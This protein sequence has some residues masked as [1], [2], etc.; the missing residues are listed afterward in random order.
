LRVW[1]GT[2]SGYSRLSTLHRGVVWAGV[3]S[4]VYAAC[5]YGML[6]AMARLGSPTQVGQFALA[7]ALATPVIVISQMQLRQLQVTD[8]AGQQTYG[9]YLGARLVASVVAVALIMTIALVSQYRG[10]M[11]A[12]IGL[13]AVAK[14]LESVSDIAHGALQRA[15]RMDLIARALILKGVASLAAFVALLALTGRLLPSVAAMAC[16]WGLVLLVYDM[17]LSRRVTGGTSWRVAVDWDVLRTLA[18]TALPL[19][20]ASGLLALSANVPR[21]VLEA[22]R[23]SEAVGLFAVAAV[24]LAILAVAHTA[25]HQATL[26]R[27]ATHFHHR[28]WGDVRRIATQVAVL[29]MAG[30]A[31]LTVLLFF[32]GEPVMRGLF[33]A[34]YVVVAPLAA[35]MAAGVALGGVGAWGVTIIMAGRRFNLQLAFV[36]AILA[37]QVP[38]AVVLISRGGLAGAGWSEFIRYVLSAVFLVGLGAYVYRTERRQDPPRA[39]PATTRVEPAMKE[40]PLRS[41]GA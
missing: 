18:R 40:L 38:L 21:Y 24:P 20:F 10:E 39:R 30:G 34:E 13:V 28:E 35:L 6:M 15:E 36:G 16:M 2:F 41:R 31:L 3:G 27:A 12:V 22:T 25:V 26:P 9:Q 7:Q 37:T 4:A 5:Q 32:A 29:Q 19:S 8:V 17:P 23:G 1:L 11:L 14:A 33:G